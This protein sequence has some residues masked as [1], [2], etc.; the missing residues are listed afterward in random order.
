MGHKLRKPILENL[1]SLSE[2]EKYL[3]FQ[4]FAQFNIKF[5]RFPQL[6]LNMTGV[7]RNLERQKNL[8]SSESVPKFQL[9]FISS[10]F[11]LKIA[12]N[13]IFARLCLLALFVYI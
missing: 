4:G 7:G 2:R 13:L 9:L 1:V 8:K 3:S 5:G 6:N 11:D 12:K 10:Q